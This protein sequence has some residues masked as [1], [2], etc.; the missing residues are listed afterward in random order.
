LQ[1]KI[2]ENKTEVSGNSAEVIFTPT[3]LYPLNQKMNMS[4]SQTFDLLWTNA[5]TFNQ[6]YKFTPAL[7]FNM[8]LNRWLLSTLSTSYEYHRNFPDNLTVHKPLASFSLTGLL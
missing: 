7:S 5:D 1:E 6:S 2:V 3:M 4:F 8:F